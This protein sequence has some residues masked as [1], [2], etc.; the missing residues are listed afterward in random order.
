MQLCAG[1][2]LPPSVSTHLNDKLALLS[3]TLP[4]KAGQGKLPYRDPP[5]RLSVVVSQRSTEAARVLQEPQKDSAWGSASANGALRDSFR[6]LQRRHVAERRWQ[7]LAADAC[8]RGGG[9]RGVRAKGEGWRGR[10]MVA[11]RQDE[12]QDE[13]SRCLR[14]RNRHHSLGSYTL[15]QY[16]QNI[17]KALHHLAS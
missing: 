14:L 6:Q 3:T 17:Q 1:H 2:A 9:E 12:I 7:Q 16:L 4:P 11:H 15:M 8:T 5:Y 10:Y 13:M